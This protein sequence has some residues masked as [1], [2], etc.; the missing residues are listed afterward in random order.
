M[1]KWKGIPV[2]L[3][4]LALFRVLTVEAQSSG[5]VHIVPRTTQKVNA[6]EAPD[7][8]LAG[9]ESSILSQSK[10][11]RVNVD[12]VLVPVKVTDAKQHPVTTLA[13][14]DFALYEDQK[15]QAIRYFSLEA[16]PISIAVLFDVSKS[17][18]D[19]VEMERAALVE[20]FRNA[21]PRD[22]YFAI[23]FSRYP[24]LLA[25]STQSIDDVQEKLT[26]IV[27][28]GPTAM[29]D[30]LYLAQAQL[31]SAKYKRRAILLITDGG[32]NASRYTMREIKKLVQESD[33]EIYAIGLFETF[34]LNSFEEFMGKKWLC[35][36]TGRTPGRTIT[37]Q[38]REKLPEA[39][40][41]ISREMRT[42]YVLGYRTVDM[43]SHRW[44]NLRV[45]L[46]SSAEGRQ[47]R[48]YYKTGYYTP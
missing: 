27:P 45:Q 39:A 47:L 10:P 43:P 46:N 12:L 17:M 13:A 37:I 26:S 19:K 31:L 29:L 30:A 24:M 25:A 16:E 41:E 11:F 33:V 44:R 36:I 6:P 28:G 32:D 21:D 35:E 4:A 3:F 34:F 18:T 23:A 9:E 8:Q 40:A 38:S 5:D 48:A 20:F 14:K 1:S 42:R 22:E 15:P 7:R 2:C